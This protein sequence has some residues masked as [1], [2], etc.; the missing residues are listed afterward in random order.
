MTAAAGLAI[1]LHAAG[2]I[3]HTFY[4]VLSRTTQAG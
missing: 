2:A 4:D 3:T 1:T